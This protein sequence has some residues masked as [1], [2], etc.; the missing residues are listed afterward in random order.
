MRRPGLARARN[1][2]SLLLVR[3]EAPPKRKPLPLPVEKKKKGQESDDDD[4]DEVQKKKL[5]MDDDDAWEMTEAER[6][7][8]LEA[9]DD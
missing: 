5:R 2:P 8:M 7:K 1:I 6:R 9:E 3:T 4:D